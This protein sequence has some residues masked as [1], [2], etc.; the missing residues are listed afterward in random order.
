MPLLLHIQDGRVTGEHNLAPGATRVGRALD[1]DICLDDSAVS[2]HHSVITVKPNAYMEG[3]FDVFVD[4][5]HSTNG[6]Q[7]NGEAVQHRRLHNEDILRT[8]SHEFKFVASRD[9]M[10]ASTRVLLPGN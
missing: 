10:A 4:D 6:T 2:G 7:V 1:N 5:L 3:T 9:T 8:G